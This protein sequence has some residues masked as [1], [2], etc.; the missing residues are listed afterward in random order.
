MIF[1]DGLSLWWKAGAQAHMRS[2]GFEHRQI[3]NINANK[4]TRYEGKIVGDSPEMCRAPDSLGFANLKAAIFA[5]SSFTSVYAVGDP[6]RFNLG[7]PDEVF[8]SIER[9]WDVAPTSKR[10]VEDILALPRVWSKIIEYKGCVVPDEVLR[11]GRRAA[12]WESA[13][14]SAR[15]A[16]RRSPGRSLE[17]R[18]WPPRCLHTP[19]L[20]PHA[21]LLRSGVRE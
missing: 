15:A 11:H 6:R 19:M 9:A 16:R 7:T 5:Y 21:P 14:K 18:R 10:I 1:H 2:R 17:S 8:R 12:K 13:A 4:G 20:T 3:R